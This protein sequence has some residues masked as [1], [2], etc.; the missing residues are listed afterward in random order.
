MLESRRVRHIRI[1]TD[2]ISA[3]DK[4]Q[5]LIQ[6][7]ARLNPEFGRITICQELVIDPQHPE[8][9]EVFAVPIRDADQKSFL[10]QLT[11]AFPGQVEDVGDANSELVTQLTE[12]GQIALFRGTTGAPLSDPPADLNYLNANKTGGDNSGST[13]PPKPTPSG[14]VA[15]PGT[16]AEGSTRPNELVTVLVWVVN[17]PARH[18]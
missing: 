4:V 10:N 17:T 18:H 2:V 13:P 1:V 3:S 9:A 7:D 5:T 8:D 11:R 16:P 15:R 6:N 12:M 14:V